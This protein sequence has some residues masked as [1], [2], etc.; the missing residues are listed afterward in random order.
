VKENR[1][2]QNTTSYKDVFDRFHGGL[3][4]R[5]NP[6]IPPRGPA[7][8]I[9]EALDRQEA[10]RYWEE[11]IV[12]KGLTEGSMA[13]V[14]PDPADLAEID[15][16]HA[17]SGHKPPWQAYYAEVADVMRLAKRQAWGRIVERTRQGVL[18]G[19]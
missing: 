2:P 17:R 18:K 15:R 14:N 8:N 11:R 4:E 3:Q 12:D 13:L 10:E 7:S 1:M 16:A 9:Q 5:R 19:E 6:Y